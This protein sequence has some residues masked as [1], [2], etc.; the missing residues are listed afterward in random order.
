MRL[1]FTLGGGLVV[2]CCASGMYL[3]NVNVNINTE[4]NM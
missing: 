1:V 4:V 2:L 3:E